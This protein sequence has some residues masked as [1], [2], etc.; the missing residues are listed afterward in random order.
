MTGAAKRW[1]TG[2]LKKPWICAEC[3]SIVST[4]SVPALESR[5]ATSLAEIGTRGLSLRSWRA[6]P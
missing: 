4:R 2:V 6:Y 3:R 1:S 5:S